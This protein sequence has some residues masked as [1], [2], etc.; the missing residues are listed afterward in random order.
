MAH[1]RAERARARRVGSTSPRCGGRCPLRNE[2]SPRRGGGVGPRSPR[3]LEKRICWRTIMTVVIWRDVTRGQHGGSSASHTLR[4]A[5]LMRA[6]YLLTLCL[7]LFRYCSLLLLSL[8]LRLLR[9]LRQRRRPSPSRAS[10]SRRASR[11][12]TRP[13]S[14][15]RRH[16]A[17]C[18]TR[19]T[20]ASPC[21]RSTRSIS[22]RSSSTRSRL[23]RR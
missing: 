9:L 20:R 19:S 18:A 1:R 5:C 17:C 16:C 15:G 14:T 22:S 7:L 8:L 12:G 6:P 10:P 23:S 3:A 11:R 4:H 21:R 2:I 13:P